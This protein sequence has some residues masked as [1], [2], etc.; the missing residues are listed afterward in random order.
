MGKLVARV[1]GD[2]KVE[3]EG[4]QREARDGTKGE[5]TVRIRKK[6]LP[7]SRQGEYQQGVQGSSRLEAR[8]RDSGH[9]RNLSRWRV[10]LAKEEVLEEHHKL[11]WPFRNE[12]RF[13][14]VGVVPELVAAVVADAVAP[15]SRQNLDFRLHWGSASLV[16][17]HSNWMVRRKIGIEVRR[18]DWPRRSMRLQLVSLPIDDDGEQ[19]GELEHTRIARQGEQP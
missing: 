7:V 18:M 12:K 16:H 6:D 15:S 4:H 8:K 1:N 11:L 3:E 19:P 13:L 2:L 9:L 14:P 10:D 17:L 5:R